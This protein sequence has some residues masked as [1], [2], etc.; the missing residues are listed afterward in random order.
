MSGASFLSRRWEPE[1]SQR[2]YRN[3]AFEVYLQVQS[4]FSSGHLQQVQGLQSHS[5]PQ[6]QHGQQVGLS[7]F[8]FPNLGVRVPCG[9]AAR[10]D[11]G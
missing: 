2:E 9:F 11:L 8:I 1:G 7:L 10:I 5:G 4:P 6:V 3:C